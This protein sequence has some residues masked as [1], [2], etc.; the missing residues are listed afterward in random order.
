M[1]SP[2]HGHHPVDSRAILYRMA[3][4]TAFFVIIILIIKILFLDIVAVSGDQMAPSIIRGDRLLVLRLPYLPG[5]PAIMGRARG[6][7]VIFSFPS[8]KLRGARTSKGR[9][10]LRIAGVSGDTVAVDSGVF[11][12]SRARA[13]KFVRR[14]SVVKS[15]V[16][17]AEFSPRDFLE[18]QRIPGPGDTLRLDSANLPRL[19]SAYAVIK[20][21]NPSSVFSLTAKLYFNDTLA[22]DYVIA[23]FVLYKGPLDS[24]PDT[25]RYDWFFWKR[26]QEYLHQISGGRKTAISFTFSKDGA[27]ITRYRV[28]SRFLFLLAD[29]WKHGFDSRYFGPVAASRVFGRPLC[30]VWSFTNHS[31]T[32]RGLNLARLGR[33]VR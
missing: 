6:T 9:G 12:N 33:I 15:E 23:D 8:E 5:L 31:D 24:I 14:D 4:Q 32:K 21:E 27:V 26:L 2:R 16:L 18:P 7:P 20:Q 1:H 11:K 25:C 10:Y 17:P 3:R 19:F 29:N 28:K 13:S 22:T 30:V